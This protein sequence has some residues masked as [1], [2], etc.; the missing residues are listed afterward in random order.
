M[1]EITESATEVDVHVG[2]VLRAIRKAR[3]LTQEGLAQAL[4]ITFQQIQKYE[5]GHNRISASKMFLAARALGVSPAAF[6]EGADGTPDGALS[7][8]LA[9]FFAED[10]AVEVATGYLRLTPARRRAIVALIAS[11]VDE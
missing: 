4:G 7:G 8:P 9:A 5:L 3:G 2:K 6:F 10:G 11:M 1:P